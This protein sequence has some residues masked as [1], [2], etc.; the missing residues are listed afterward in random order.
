MILSKY[1]N[2][3]I[4]QIW[5]VNIWTNQTDIAPINCLVQ[6]YKS[7]LAPT[8]SPRILS[9]PPAASISHILNSNNL[10]SMVQS[11]RTSTSWKNSTLIELPVKVSPIDRN[12]NRSH[13]QHVLEEI[14]IISVVC[15]VRWYLIISVQLLARLHFTYIW[16]VRIRSKRVPLGIV[17]RIFVKTV[18]AS[19]I[20]KSRWAVNYLL[21]RQTCT[22]SSQ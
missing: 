12:D 22:L 7:I 16:V 1:C 3:I 17:K 2:Q 5:V 11:I 20:S 8:T 19:I 14:A 4:S 6:P 13:H 9:Y 15:H 18:P 21:L 10:N